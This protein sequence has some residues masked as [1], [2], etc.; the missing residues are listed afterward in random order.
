M[1]QQGFIGWLILISVLIALAT[2]AVVLFLNVPNS[3]PGDFIYPVKEIREN[4]RLGANELSF[5]GR[6][7][8]YIDA[9]NER[10]REIITLIE[11][12]ENEEKITKALERLQLAQ[13]KALENIEK[14][15]SKGTNMTIYIGKLEASLQR[16][17]Q[18]LQDLTYQVPPSLYDIV[19]KTILETDNNLIK[20]GQ[21]RTY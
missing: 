9:T 16:Q 12:K 5:E 7:N 10:T 15:R 13:K 21:M 11:R 18:S 20:I 8:V 1:G 4:L 14:A 2:S 17:Q 3:L 6:A 19:N